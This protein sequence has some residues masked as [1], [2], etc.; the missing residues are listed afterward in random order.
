MAEI[1]KMSSKKDKRKSF[2]DLKATTSTTIEGDAAVSTSSSKPSKKRKNHADAGDLVV[3]TPANVTVDKTEEPSTKKQKKAKK[4]EEQDNNPLVESKPEEES[5]KNRKK[6]KKTEK[7]PN[8]TPT[9]P[10]QNGKKNV[11]GVG[12]AGDPATE[13]PAKKKSKKVEAGEGME[14]GSVAPVEGES[15]ING[16]EARNTG[17]DVQGVVNQSASK[18]KAAQK[19]KKSGEKVVTKADEIAVQPESI[20]SDQT[21]QPVV[22]ETAVAER[23]PK[24]RK[25]AEERVKESVDGLVTQPKP[26]MSAGETAGEG[27]PKKKKRKKT[28]GNVTSTEDEVRTESAKSTK[29]QQPALPSVEGKEAEETTERKKGKKKGKN[30]DAK[31]DAKEDDSKPVETPAPKPLAVR[32]PSK[33]TKLGPDTSKPAIQ[34]SP[35]ATKSKSISAP[36]KS[37]TATSEVASEPTKKSK[38]AKAKDPSPQPEPSSDDDSDV[39]GDVQFGSGEDDEVHLHGFSTDDDDSSD[40]ETGMDF[41][42][43]P[44]DIT[45]LPTVAKDDAIVKRKLDKAKRQP[46]RILL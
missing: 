36:R 31:K 39:E 28:E 23:K 21:K 11:G 45:K 20:K 18:D 33:K 15:K 29:T 17:V 1:T 4:D 9:K 10:E 46:V 34:V 14:G 7:R 3:V 30:D 41:E 19:K 24:K 32:D 26:A 27:E 43:A 42:S 13:V 5:T 12:E 25:K 40:E 37:T 2:V 22:E 16:K 38:K 35:M 6:D 8:Q 44:L